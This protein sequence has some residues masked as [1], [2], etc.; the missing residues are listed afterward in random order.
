[1]KQ[2]PIISIDLSSKFRIRIHKITLNLLGDP[3]Y[4]QIMINPSTNVLAIARSH[5]EDPLALK[6]RKS[7]TDGRGYFEIY[8]KSLMQ[9]LQRLNI[10]WEE[11]QSYR[12]YGEMDSGNRLAQFRMTCAKENE[13]YA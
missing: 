2:C 3:E 6:I 10:H 5:P 13:D 7:S 1:M 4:I 9:G 8:S 12:F 11:N